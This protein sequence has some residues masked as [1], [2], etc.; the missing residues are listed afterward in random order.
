MPQMVGLLNGLGGGAST[1]VAVGECWRLMAQPAGLPLD[2]LLTTL[3][4]VLIGAITLT[5]SLVAFGKLQGVITSAPVIFPLQ[6]SLN[7]VLL[8]A[9]LVGGAYLIHGP[10]DAAIVLILLGMALLLGVLLVLPVGGADMP[11]VISLLNAS[12]GLAASA[13][14]FVFANQVL[15]I[16][17]A[18]VGAS[19]LILT[20]IMCQAMNR[21]LA[22]VLFSGFG[23]GDRPTGVS[24]PSGTELCV[25]AIDADEGAVILAYARSVIIVPAMAT[26]PWLQITA[27]GSPLVPDV[28]INMNGSRGPASRAMT[29]ASLCSSTSA[30]H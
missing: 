19:G 23:S 10:L 1:L 7:G 21:S 2:T 5:G 24:V 6:Q 27:F 4:G 20:R 12:S 16:A 29:G 30:A 25:R 3:L 14:G 9:F 11:V 22:N 8:L 13:V 18:L 15:I 26:L 17:G 28:Y